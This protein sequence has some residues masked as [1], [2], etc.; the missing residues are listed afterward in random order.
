MT[1]KEPKLSIVPN[2]FDVPPSD[3]RR[4]RSERSRKK[5]LQSMWDLMVEGDME[6]S[7]AAI[8]ERAGV[9]LRSVFRHFEDM[10]TISRELILLAESEVMPL[11]MKPFKSTD[12]KEQLLEIG[13]RNA[14]IWEKIKIPHTAGAIRRFKSDILMDDYKRSRMKELSSVKAI[15]P[16]D[17]PD[18]EN[19]LL[20][21][22][23]ALSFSTWLRLREERGLSLN[24]VK[25]VTRYIVQAL[26]NKT[27]A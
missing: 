11:F 20:A 25:D 18:Y 3:G 5:I 1:A 21:L 4:Q 16:K 23:N 9:G 26:I 6:P 2:D 19:L 10:D 12:W 17:V 15:L 13:D 8:A 22:D 24:R 14:S 27:P 7:A